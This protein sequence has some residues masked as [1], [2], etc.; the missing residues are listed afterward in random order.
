MTK[1]DDLSSSLFDLS[2]K[3][4]LFESKIFLVATRDLKILTLIGSLNSSIL[5]YRSA[6]VGGEKVSKQSSA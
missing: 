3:I 4:A 5:S 1:S 6:E 2:R